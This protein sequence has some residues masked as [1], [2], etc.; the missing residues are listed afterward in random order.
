MSNPLK[1]ISK[2]D[3]ELRVG[4]YAVLFGGR[5]LTGEFFTAKTDFSSS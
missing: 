2:S 4:N 3:D 5:D 1:T